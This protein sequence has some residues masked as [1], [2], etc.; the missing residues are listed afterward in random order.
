MIRELFLCGE[1]E[2]GRFCLKSG[3]VPTKLSRC[4]FLVRTTMMSLTVVA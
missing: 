1:H 3:G 2:K 4:F